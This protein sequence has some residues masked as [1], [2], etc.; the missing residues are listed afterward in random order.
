MSDAG[1]RLHLGCGADR[2]AGWINIDREPGPAVDQVFDIRDL[3]ERFAPGT[4]SAV[5]LMHAINYLTLWEAR[6]FFRTCLSLLAPGG[7][8]AIETADAASAARRFLENIDGDFDAYLEGIRAFPGFGLDHLTEQRTYTPNSMAWTPWH[9]ERELRLAGFARTQVSES[10]THAKW[11]DFRVEA[12]KAAAHAPVDT[13]TPRHVLFVVDEDA[14]HVT[15]HLRAR[16]FAEPLARRAFTVTILD[17]RRNAVEDITSAAARADVVVMSKVPSIALMHRVRASARGPVLFDFTDAL[18]LPHHQGHGW[19]DLHALLAAADGLLCDNE[20]IARYGRQYNAH[21]HLWPASTQVELFDAERAKYAG[22]SRDTVRLGWVGSQGTATA[23]HAIADALAAVAQRVPNLELRVLGC[24]PASVPV[25]PGMRT[26]VLPSYDEATMIAEM[27]AMDI[28]LFPAPLSLEDFRNRGPLK[29]ALYMSAGIPMV[30]QRGGE[31]DFIVQQGANG[32]TADGVQEWTAHLVTLANDA[33]LRAQVGR[34]ARASMNGRTREAI[35]DVLVNIL[36]EAIA[37]P[38]REAAPAEVP[39]LTGTSDQPIALSGTSLHARESGRPRVL[40]VADVRGWIFERH[41][42]TLRSRLSDEFDIDIG[43]LGQPIDEAHYDV[44]YPLEYN[45]IPPERI[46]MPWKYVTGLRSHI[47]WDGVPPAAL[48]RYLSRYYQRTHMVS[49]RLLSLFS[50]HLPS[51]EYVSHGIDMSRF[52]PVSRTRAPGTPLR[53]GWAGNR[54]SP[55]KGFS[56][57]IRPLAEIPGVELVVRGYS[58]RNLTLEEMPEFYAGIDVYVCA[59]STEGNNNSLIEAAATAC[60]IV[61]SDTGTVPEYLPHNVAALVVPRTSAAFRE[62]IVRLR[63][64][65]ALRESLGAAAAKAVH[66]AWSWD[67]RAEHYRAFLRAA[68]SGSEEAKVR[69]SKGATQRSLSATIAGVLDT[70]QRAMASGN[71]SAAR[72]N[73]E[74]L[75]TLDP[76]NAEFRALNRELHPTEHASV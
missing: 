76:T 33:S 48:S 7:E 75:V 69:L 50:A 70:L 6:N 60:A 55:A 73:A 24:D 29:G 16:M 56:E 40:M 59:S 36:N 26:S 58:D 21:V 32:Y 68:V 12:F 2:W 1:L 57:L 5:H 53:V 51:A 20:V 65:A 72:S 43:Y 31:L 46:T 19:Q 38:R 13:R 25:I 74:R 30:C 63:D 47:S 15:A 44:I 39:A 64:D 22:T 66:P 34:H 62:A 49:Q 52:V 27:V 37:T 4:C 61:T 10:R 17:A 42:Q 28:G 35:T 45:L 9:L 8:L 67:V 54:A 41:A 71:I 3:H 23:L 18:W 14:G 11:R